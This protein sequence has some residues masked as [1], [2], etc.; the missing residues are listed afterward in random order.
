MRIGRII[1]ENLPVFLIG[2]V[3]YNFI[4]IL[5]RGYTH[6]TMGIVGGVCMVTLCHTF[7]KVLRMA[8][9]K[10][11][12]LGAVIITGLELVTGCI[13]NLWMG[14]NIWDYSQRRFQFLGQVCLLFS[15]FWFFLCIPVV[16]ISKAFHRIIGRDV[17][18]PISVRKKDDGL[19]L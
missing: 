9:W 13:V 2:A 8:W 17:S 12:L 11:C 15:V 18:A 1:Y 19:F 16:W 3:L 4:E 14:W 10:K 5:F 7:G 6:W